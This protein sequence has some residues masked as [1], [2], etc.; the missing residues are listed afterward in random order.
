MSNNRIFTASML[1]SIGAFNIAMLPWWAQPLTMDGLMRGMSLDESQSGSLIAVELFMVC[2]ASLLMSVRVSKLP[3]RRVSCFSALMVMIANALSMQSDGTVLMLLRAGTGVFEGV[4]MACA[5]AAIASNRDPDRAYGLQ[6]IGNILF[7]SAFLALAPFLENLAG[8]KSI[9]VG[10]SIAALVLLP[11]IFAL[12][13]KIDVTVANVR[14]EQKGS[15]FIVLL[16][17]LM[18][19]T[20]VAIPWF[21]LVDIGSRTD[22]SIHQVGLIAGC[23]GL[24]GLLGGALATRLGRS[25][26]RRLILACGLAILCVTTFTLVYWVNSVVFIV[27]VFLFIACL[28]TLFPYL[29]GLAA[30]LDPKGGLPAAMGAVYIL[31]GST[32]AFLGGHAVKDFGLESMAW[33]VTLG[34]V[35]CYPL[36]L[37]VLK[38]RESR[39]LSLPAELAVD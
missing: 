2:I 19:G 10:F 20:T 16:V 21:F 3:L 4:L 25:I 27:S 39:E 5:T 24:G 23:S 30:D 12:P 29:F 15:G 7:C 14:F 34:A 18:W 6:N 11:I 28:Y 9:F 17:M 1:G 36:L 8:P 13:R 33:L 26:N 37:V 31:T 35:I 22:L 32:G 38:E